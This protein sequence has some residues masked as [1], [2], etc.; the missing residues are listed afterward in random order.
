MIPS[1]VSV[2]TRLRRGGLYCAVDGYS[3]WQRSAVAVAARPRRVLLA[4]LG[5]CTL[6]VLVAGLLVAL[7]TGRLFEFVSFLPFDM[8]APIVLVFSVV[9]GDVIYRRNHSVPLLA[10][11]VLRGLLLAGVLAGL[12]FLAFGL[13]HLNTRLAAA[14]G[15][16]H[17][18]VH[19]RTP[20]VLPHVIVML[21]VTLLLSL[22]VRT[23]VFTKLLGLARTSVA[24]APATL[25]DV[26]QTLPLVL[27]V[28]FFVAFSSDSWRTFGLMSISQLTVLV[29]LLLACAAGVIRHTSREDVRSL[30]R[31]NAAKQEVPAED[32]DEDRDLRELAAA[33]VTP[34]RIEV[35]H[36]ISTEVQ[37]QW[38]FHIALR[39]VFAGI[40][41]ALMIWLATGLTI[42]PGRLHSFL[43]A[44]PTRVLD[45]HIGTLR[46]YLSREGLSVAAVLGAFASLVFVGVAISDKDKRKGL[47]APERVRLRRLL[48]LAGTYQEAI[49]RRVWLGA[50]GRTWPTYSAFLADEP[51]RWKTEPVDLGSA[52]TDGSSHSLSASRWQAAWNRVTGELYIYRGKRLGEVEVIA[53]SDEW[54]ALRARLAGW[55]QHQYES[56]SLAWL[57]AR[58]SAS[59]VSV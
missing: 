9:V 31:H 37:N 59:T 24:S 5:W 47:F 29:G 23:G 16:A 15:A 28:L 11:S 53:V 34:R 52:W 18:V 51:E 8:L 21:A 56:D 3:R 45:L 39:V 6:W 25:R 20:S 12:P 13:A 46:L 55:E 44:R 40:F 48:E 58:V 54:E 7:R 32:V 42:G 41:V 2:E 10:A 22:E 17:A 50:P 1:R 26:L 4:G 14:T 30:L 27:T 35:K 49:T 43:D 19:A 38:M 33:G 57:R 36:D